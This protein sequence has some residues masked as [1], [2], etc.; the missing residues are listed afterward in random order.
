[1]EKQ[2]RAFGLVLS[3]C[4]SLRRYDR[5]LLRRDIVAGLTVASVAVPQAMAYALLAGVF[6]VCGIYTAIVV[7]ALGSLFGSSARLINGPTNAISLVVFGVVSG[8]GTGPQD[9]AWVGL[10]ALL[11]VLAGLIQIGLSLL[12]LGG[13]AR[14]I[15]DGE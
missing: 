8:V 14:H 7:T 6:S 3:V 10:V 9:P 12:K 1:M 5:A 15:P 11:A 4:L 2:G 13:L